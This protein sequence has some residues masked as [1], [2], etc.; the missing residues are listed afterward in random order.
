M[1]PKTVTD[2]AAAPVRTR[3]E[4]EIFSDLASLCALPG[5]VH[6]IVMLCVRDNFISAAPDL[7]AQ[8]LEHL[9]SRSRLIRTEITTLV[10]LLIKTAIDFSHP[11]LEVLLDYMARTEQLLQ[12]LHH[13]L[14]SKLFHGLPEKPHGD[15]PALPLTSGEALREPIFYG[16]ES[17]YGFQYR[18][19]APSKYGADNAWLV[20]NMGFSIDDART[21]VMAVAALQ[22]RK[23]TMALRS[24]RFMARE[25]WTML[26]GFV[27]TVTEVASRA[28]LDVRLVERILEA[29]VFSDG[30]RNAGFTS[31]HAY[32]AATGTPL[33]RKGPDEY[34]SLQQYSLYE[35]L[36]EAPFFWLGA[37]K[38]YQPTALANRGRFTEAFARE[39][40]QKVFGTAHVYPNVDVWKSKGVKLG[41]IDVLVVFG[42][43]VMVLQAKSKRLTLEARKGNDLQIRDD[44][45][46]AIQQ[47]SDQA[48][49]CAVAVA[50]SNPNLT[51]SQGNAIFL[52]HP[53]EVVY[54]IC[55]VA[56]HYPALGF[57]ARQFLQ[58]EPAPGL[59]PPLVTD[60][61]ALDAMTEML[62]SPLRLLSYF[63]LR[64]R[65]GEQLI[66]TH[67]LTLLSYHLKLNLWLNGEYDL[68]YLE[69]DIAVDLDIAM[70]ARREGLAGRRTPEG[71]LTRVRGTSVGRI[72]S[73]IEALADPSTI[74][75]GMLL[76]EM[77]QETLETVSR[78]IRRIA[79]E[80][81]QDG[82]T[83]DLTVGL[84]TT[85]AGL[86]IHCTA[87][88]PSSAQARLLAHCEA[89]KYSQKADRWFGLTLRPDE[90]LWF[91]LK[92]DHAWAY[93]K[94]LEQVLRQW[95]KNTGRPMNAVGL[96]MPSK[97]GRNA[98]CP[99]GSGQKYKKCC[100]AR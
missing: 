19:F 47:S 13:A 23:V 58:F 43:R 33:L 4:E 34:I 59:A 91:G 20:A 15:T 6:T 2:E 1:S 98:P 83:H 40:L 18:D 74:D 27:F 95:P 79:A 81:R 75:L 29:F 64:A 80:A 42:D 28:G 89:R 39:R 21:V 3:T 93:D 72:I 66:A 35:A 46:K 26:P 84:G 61:F 85:S 96:K 37:D 45:E 92:L 30:D 78:G 5:Y 71:I 76:L 70:A 44:F 22:D 56:D 11:G 54:P 86:T 52:P 24:L 57:Q 68:F 77:N 90:T 7:K 65:F 25:S 16:G 94:R 73:E 100:L 41:E 99:C 8:D 63:K 31:L 9:F 60:V 14:G 51:D 36:Y 49:L 38:G 55:I 87:S 82:K 69:D 67:E 10:G 97:V 48:R 88:E 53:V 12:E 32:N 62:E 17:A 50:G